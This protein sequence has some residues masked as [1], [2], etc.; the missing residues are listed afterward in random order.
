MKEIAPIW[1]FLLLLFFIFTFFL[2][3]ES[4]E[5]EVNAERFIKEMESVLGHFSQ[6]TSFGHDS[7][8]DY[9]SSSDMDFGT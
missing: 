4:E 2:W 9:S 3:R 6:D 7:K 5:V 8:E 1:H